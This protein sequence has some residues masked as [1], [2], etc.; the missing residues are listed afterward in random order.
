MM[1]PAKRIWTSKT[2]WVG[3]LEIAT[4]VLELIDVNVLANDGAGW[5]AVGAGLL[6][7]LLRYITKQPVT[8]S[9]RERKHVD[10]S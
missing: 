9:G 8:V 6:T 4:G 3:V 7:I 10:A 2:F 1:V 5:V